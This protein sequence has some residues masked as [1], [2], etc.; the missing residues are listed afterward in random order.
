MYAG[1]DGYNCFG[2][3]PNNPIGL[4][5]EFFEDGDDVIAEWTPT[6]NYEGYLNFLHGGIQATLLD[7]VAAWVIYAK[8]KTSGVT[9]SLDVEYLKPVFLSKGKVR[10]RANLLSHEKNIA[11]INAQIEDADGV[12]RSR[13]TARYFVYPPKVAQAKFNYPIEQE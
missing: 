11:T 6:K 12:V 7:E 10:L 9:T 1:M 8:L 3:A 4:R 13:A 5:L 2:C